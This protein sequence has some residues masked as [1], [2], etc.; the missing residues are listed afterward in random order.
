MNEHE[1]FEFVAKEL[2][3]IYEDLDANVQ[4]QI[5]LRK[6]IKNLLDVTNGA[7]PLYNQGEKDIVTRVLT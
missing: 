7:E 3:A 5:L 4:Q 6:F 2:A 1:R